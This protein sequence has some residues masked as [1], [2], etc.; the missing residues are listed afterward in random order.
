MLMNDR[1][2]IEQCCTG[3][4]VTFDEDPALHSYKKFKATGFKPIEESMIYPFVGSNVRSRDVT[5]VVPGEPARTAQELLISFGVSSFG[6]DARLAPSF[7]IFT[8]VTG[9]DFPIVDPKRK[10]DGYFFDYE[11][12][13]AIIP[14]NS[15]LLGHTI[16]R[17]RMPPDVMAICL[18]K[19][20]YARCGLIVNVTPLEP[21]WE[22]YVTIEV[23]NTTPLPARV[24]AN[25]GICQ[26]LFLKGELPLTTYNA[27]QGKYQNQVGVTPARM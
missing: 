17:F 1:W 14:P 24:Y 13:T 11:G 23:S 25:E 16:E 4:W 21:G 8:P 15:F 10:A 19:S 9:G 5:H 20:T 26:F 3:E 18:G 22:G 27:R 7:K 12:E 2:I 6:Y